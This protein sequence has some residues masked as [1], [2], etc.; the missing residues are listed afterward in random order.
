[1]VIGSINVNSLLL[2][3]DEVRELIKDKGFHILAINEKKLDST[4]A[5]NLLAID[6]Y[7]LHMRDRDRHEEVAVYV[8]DSLKHHRRI[9]IPEGGLEFLV[10]KLNLP[11]L[12]RL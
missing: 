8:R 5:D 3:S 1:M 6:G 9:D 4:I 2:H 12:S 11:K 7:A 10:L